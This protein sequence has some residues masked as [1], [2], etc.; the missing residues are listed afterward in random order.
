MA[1]EGPDHR[2]LSYGW[3]VD[4]SLCNSDKSWRPFDAK[5]LYSEGEQALSEVEH[6]WQGTPSGAYRTCV[7]PFGIYDLMGNVE[8]WVGARAG[9]R[10]SGAL[11]GGFWAKPWSGC[12]GTN[13]AHEATF[14]FYETGFRC[15]AEASPPPPPPSSLPGS[16]GGAFDEPSSAPR[17]GGM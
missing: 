2:P 13:D 14:M 17:R 9:R 3:R 1:C 5:K 8:E 16:D 12:R 15:C 10:F 11:K 6:L 7:S 4:V